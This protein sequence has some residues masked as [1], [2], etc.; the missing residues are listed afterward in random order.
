MNMAGLSARIV[1]ANWFTKIIRNQ[2]EF[3]VIQFGLSFFQP[4]RRALGGSDILLPIF[5]PTSNVLWLRLRIT[6]R[7][8][9]AVCE[10]IVF[11]VAGVVTIA[12]VVLTAGV[13]ALGIAVYDAFKIDTENT[14]AVLLVNQDGSKPI[15]IGGNAIAQLIARTKLQTMIFVSCIFKTSALQED[16]VGKKFSVCS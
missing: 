10:K 6:E 2:P 4:I 15:M 8:N 16:A 7:A 14:T 1:I 5:A 3:G 9:V 12:W 13:I 11:N